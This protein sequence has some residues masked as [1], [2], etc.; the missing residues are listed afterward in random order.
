MKCDAL[1]YVAM[2][3]VQY[4]LIGDHWSATPRLHART[5]DSSR[6]FQIP[7]SI[8]VLKYSKIG[9]NWIIII[10]FISSK[11]KI[12]GLWKGCFLKCVAETTTHIC[13]IT[14]DRLSIRGPVQKLSLSV[15]CISTQRRAAL[16]YTQSDAS[17]EWWRVHS[18]ARLEPTL[19][20]IDNVFCFATVFILSVYLTF[21]VL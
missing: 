21:S 4:R 1:L 12:K 13:S 9:Q 16:Q 19:Y 2:D 10:T 18:K 17:I 6:V 7:G 15:K 14:L 5:Y 20:F 8:F 11:L 3:R